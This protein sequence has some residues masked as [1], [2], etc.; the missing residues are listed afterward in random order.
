MNFISML[1]SEGLFN[2]SEDIRLNNRVRIAGEL[3]YIKSYENKDGK[4]V[5]IY[6]ETE[7]ERKIE[8]IPTSIGVYDE[9][10]LIS[11]VNSA[12]KPALDGIYM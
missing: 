2:P 11:K 7:H 8:L 9:G 5:Q 10:V 3:M 4:A 1:T 6:D 12:G